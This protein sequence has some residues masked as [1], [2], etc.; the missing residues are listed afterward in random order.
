MAQ[1]KAQTRVPTSGL[2]ASCLSGGADVLPGQR[3]GDGLCLNGRGAHVARALHRSQQRSA[4]AQLGEQHLAGLL[5]GRGLPAANAAAPRI[6]DLLEVLSGPV[7]LSL[8]GLVV[9][10]SLG[11]ALRCGALPL[12]LA[13]L[14]LAELRVRSR[15]LLLSLQLFLENALCRS[16]GYPLLCS[17]LWKIT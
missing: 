14:G 17:G 13:L 8:L 9:S 3:V 4:Q 1:N 16:T 15:G 10:L 2:A 11:V 7:V 6:D 12:S 5:R